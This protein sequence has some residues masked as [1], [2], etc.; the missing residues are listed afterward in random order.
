MGVSWPGWCDT[1]GL[2]AIGLPGAPGRAG[3]LES[4]GG[5]V[6][7][8]VRAAAQSGVYRG[9]RAAHTARPPRPARPGPQPGGTS[10]RRG[11]YPHPGRRNTRPTGGGS[12]GGCRS[13]GYPSQGRGGASRGPERGN[14]AAVL[15]EPDHGGDSGGLPAS[16]IYLFEPPRSPRYSPLA[17]F[18]SKK[19]KQNYYTHHALSIA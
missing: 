5:A 1:G 6:P 9:H 18:L 11:R 13:M 12:P 4:G 16:S 3:G 19:K 10:R 7:H 15:D 2:G 17:L 8:L 14:P